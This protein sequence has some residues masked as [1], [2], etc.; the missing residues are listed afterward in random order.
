[1]I[2]DLHLD[3]ITDYIRDIIEVHIQ[4][5]QDADPSVSLKAT[6]FWRVVED[7]RACKELLVSY[8][9]GIVPVLLKNII[10]TTD[11]I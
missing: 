5:C 11:E 7:S 1:M 9:G 10:Y 4:L 2:T 6:E 3:H 8:L